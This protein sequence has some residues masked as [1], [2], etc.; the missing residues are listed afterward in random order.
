MKFYCTAKG[1]PHFKAKFSLLGFT[2]G[3]K[4]CT[5]LSILLLEL[6]PRVY[7]YMADNQ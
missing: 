4:G 6:R 7:A 3:C 2:A 5:A 1:T